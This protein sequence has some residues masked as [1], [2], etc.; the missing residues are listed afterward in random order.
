MAVHFEKFGQNGS[1]KNAASCFD[2]EQ[3]DEAALYREAL[4]TIAGAAI[5]TDAADG[6]RYLNPAAERLLGYGLS[7]VFGWSLTAILTF[8]GEFPAGMTSVAQHLPQ[9]QGRTVTLDRRSGGSIRVQISPLTL[10]AKLG[11][12]FML[13][14]VLERVP[15]GA[16]ALGSAGQGIADMEAKVMMD[17]RWGKRNRLRA[18]V[19]LR[20]ADGTEEHGEIRD[21]GNKGLYVETDHPERISSCVIIGVVSSKPSV[22]CLYRV[23]T[24]VTHR[25]RTGVGLMLPEGAAHIITSL[26]R[27]SEQPE[28]AVS[29]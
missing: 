12:G 28:R 7:E 23:A 25:Q 14:E 1:G 15:A 4:E 3:T 22:R 10:P 18:P 2:G 16:G 9:V 5:V 27:S 13:R 17:A 24:L 21:I 11:N 8:R 20:C 26:C 29:G 19:I 6:I